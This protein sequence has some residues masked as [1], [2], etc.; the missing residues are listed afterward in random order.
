MERTRIPVGRGMLTGLLVGLVLAAIYADAVAK[1]DELGALLNFWAMFVVPFPVGA[2]A[3]RLLRMPHWGVVAIAGGIATPVLGASLGRLVP[4]HDIFGFDEMLVSGVYVLAAVLGYVAAAW[5]A[6]ESGG[7]WI[8]ITVAGVLVSAQVASAQVAEPF[9]R[10]QDVQAFERS[11]VPLLAPAVP[12]GYTLA[13]A[14]PWS[15]DGGDYGPAIFLEFER[16]RGDAYDPT[17]SLI[18]VFV[19]P[20]AAATPEAMCATPYPTEG[21]T[22]RPAADGHWVRQDNDSLTLVVARHSNALVQ[23]ESRHAS[24]AELLTVLRTVRPVSAAYLASA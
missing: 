21:G 5:W 14:E 17:W 1:D 10:W 2:V 19:H 24:E 13:R 7:W 12:A 15:G 4:D 18:Q 16:G 20:G 8:R 22:C 3:A 11:G 6:G 9:R 23:L